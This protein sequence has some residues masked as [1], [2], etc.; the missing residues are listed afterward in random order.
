MNSSKAGSN[1]VKICFHTGFPPMV[2]TESSFHCKYEQ[3]FNLHKAYH[4]AGGEPFEIQEDAV[5]KLQ[6]ANNPHGPGL[7][8]MPSHLMMYARECVQNGRFSD[9]VGPVV[10]LTLARPSCPRSSNPDTADLSDSTVICAS[11]HTKRSRVVEASQRLWL[12]WT[13]EM[14]DKVSQ[15]PKAALATEGMQRHFVQP[16]SLR[17]RCVQVSAIRALLAALRKVRTEITCLLRTF[18]DTSELAQRISQLHGR[19]DKCSNDLSHSS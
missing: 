12:R 17:S 8:F 14:L 15:L 9:D 1:V 4:H 6:C 2:L 3:L 18:H 10:I 11:R 5:M 7:A 19:D 13:D 16:S